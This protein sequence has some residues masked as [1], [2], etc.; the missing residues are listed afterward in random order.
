LFGEQYEGLAEIDREIA[1]LDGS[2]G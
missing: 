2:S 1:K